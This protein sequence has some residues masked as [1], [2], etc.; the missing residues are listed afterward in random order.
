MSLRK[1]SRGM[2]LRVRHDSGRTLLDGL[3]MIPSASVSH[4][5]LPVQLEDLAL[6]L[7]DL[8]S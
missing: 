1:S 5:Q 7:R 8:F 3:L 6:Q 4:P 2:L